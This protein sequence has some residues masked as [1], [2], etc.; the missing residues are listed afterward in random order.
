[1]T[2]SLYNH[3]KVGPSFQAKNVD[4]KHSFCR[5]QIYLQVLIGAQMLCHLESGH[6]FAFQGPFICSPKSF[7]ICYQSTN[8]VISLLIV[9]SEETTPFL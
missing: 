4:S 2:V 1:M 5:Y 6:N 8:K 9:I 3:I 7:A